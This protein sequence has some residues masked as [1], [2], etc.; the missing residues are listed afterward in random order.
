MN[1][2]FDLMYVK[3]GA[4]FVWSTRHVGY[5]FE[6]SNV[7]SVS[8]EKPIHLTTLSNSPRVFSYIQFFYQMRK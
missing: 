1:N 8:E 6:P 3:G 7:K 5:Q 4:L 2:D